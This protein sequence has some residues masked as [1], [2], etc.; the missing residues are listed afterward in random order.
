MYTLMP[1]LR[2]IGTKSEGCLKTAL[3]CKAIGS[4]V[5]NTNASIKH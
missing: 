5:H 1:F 3:Y 4:G 2:V